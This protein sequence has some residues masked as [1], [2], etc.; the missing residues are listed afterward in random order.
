MAML[1][2]LGQTGKLTL[3]LQAVDKASP[4]IKKVKTETAGLGKQTKITTGRFDAFSGALSVATG[5]LIRDLTVGLTGCIVESMRLGASIDTL[6]TSFDRLLAASGA[7]TIT[8]KKLRKA[9]HGMISDVDLLTA[10]NRAMS[11]GLPVDDLDELYD[12]A[13]RV[14]VAQGMTATQSVERFTIAI[15][16]QSTKILDDFGIM[17]RLEDAYEEYAKTLGKETNEL[18]ESER[19]TAFATVAIEK[20]T[21]QAEILGDNISDAQKRQEQWN[22]SMKNF[23]SIIGRA[24][25]PLSGFVDV[26]EPLMPMFGI[27]GAQLLPRLISRLGL[28]SKAMWVF[29]GTAK[30]AAIRFG[31]FGGALGVG[32]LAL[33]ALPKDIRNVASGLAVLSGVVVSAAFAWAA[34]H[35]SMTAGLASTAILAGIGLTIAG[36]TSLMQDATASAEDFMKTFDL[37]ELEDSFTDFEAT[38]GKAVADINTLIKSGL[39][40]EAQDAIAKFAECSES[41]QAE[42][43]DQIEGHLDN[44]YEE[45]RDNVNKIASLEKH[46]K[47]E[48]AEIY[49]KANEE[50]LAKM[51]EFENYKKLIITTT[52]E[53]ITAFL[54]EQE[55]ERVPVPHPAI[56]ARMRAGKYVPPPIAYE[57]VGRHQYGGVVGLHGP[58]LALLGERE[59]ELVTPISRLRGA[60]GF[61]RPVQLSGSVQFLG[62]VH[63]HNEADEN[64]LAEKV[65]QKV[66]RRQLDQIRAMWR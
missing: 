61:G 47:D 6:R 43:V 21:D 51:E 40:G 33:R 4:A 3:V 52:E 60:G 18:T 20:L 54:K 14:G 2:G 48:V 37:G 27:M 28:G 57:R 55:E 25:G 34:Y 1:G 66:S 13:I 64:R 31:V 16:R 5:F 8:L 9:T 44:L 46:G 38:T 35:G 17:L 26:F 49:R 39:L 22:T 56:L 36:I 19:E 24:L 11:L 62:D 7:Q 41:K 12:A 30:T 42:M 23:K 10:A 45:Y 29:G 50:I 65:A 63:V 53:D 15:G 58:E 32:L 59:P